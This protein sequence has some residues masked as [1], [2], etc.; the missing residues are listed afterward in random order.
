MQ[1]PLNI[2]DIFARF[3]AGNDASPRHSFRSLGMWRGKLFCADAKGLDI[4]REFVYE[5]ALLHDI[6]VVKCDAPSIHCHG[7]RPYICHGIEGR[8]MLES[9]GL[10]RHA[11]VCERHTGSGLSVAD[12]ISQN[13]PLPTATCSP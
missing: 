5:A 7:T 11:L 10:P 6:G 8:A 1:S 9:L 13:L 12:I 2:S 3:Y 4:D